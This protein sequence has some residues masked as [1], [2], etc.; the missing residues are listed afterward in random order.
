MQSVN[1]AAGAADNTLP[2]V[3]SHRIFNI[4]YIFAGISRQSDI[5][6]CLL[7]LQTIE[8][9]TIDVVEFDLVRDQGHDVTLPII[10]TQLCE[11]IRNGRFHCLI[12]TPPCNTFSRA[13]H[14]WRYSPGPK[15][16]RNFN[17][18]LGFPWL[19]GS[20]ASV[21]S[22]ANSLIQKTVEACKLAHGAGAVFLVEHPEDL[23]KTPDDELPASIWQR[24]DIRD[25]QR[26][27]AAFT[28]ALFQCDYGAST[29]LSIASSSKPTRLLGNL[30][31]AANEP[32]QGWPQFDEHRNYLG[33]LP[34]HCSHLKHPPL[35]G[36]SQSGG[37]LTS[38]AAAYPP[39]MCHRIAE[40]IV[41]SLKSEQLKRGKH[42]EQHPFPPLC[43][44]PPEH[45]DITD[46]PM[47]P[48]LT[49]GS[50]TEEDL[51]MD[52]QDDSNNHLADDACDETSDEDEEGVRRF[53]KDE[54]PG[55][56]GPPLDTN[57]GGRRRQFHDG[58]GLPYQQGGIQLFGV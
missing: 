27:T 43:P 21:C 37:F 49:I 15:P 48:D 30:S 18:P 36:R 22:V 46:C 28:W 2:I 12:M 55:G 9:C 38:P 4:L 44:T 41:H 29:G 39:A 5:K 47:Q 1:E 17:W 53:K 25:L 19:E 10:W 24:E 35:I 50:D 42:D 14:S 58:F 8:D 56:L 16:L 34:Q 51:V 54:K 6:E 45:L 20:D 33:P 7:N 32:F 3:P 40:L 13:R 26:T 52:L 31:A 11:S 23:G 57:W